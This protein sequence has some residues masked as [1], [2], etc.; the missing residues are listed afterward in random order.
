MPHGSA[1]NLS[2]LLFFFFFF[3]YFIYLRCTSPESVSHCSSRLR[4]L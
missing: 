3:L 4:H 1:F 2:L